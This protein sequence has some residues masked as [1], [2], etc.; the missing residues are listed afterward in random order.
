MNGPTAPAVRQIEHLQ[1]GKGSKGSFQAHVESGRKLKP[2]S[3]CIMGNDGASL[4]TQRTSGYYAIMD[5]S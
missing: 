3:A 5:F 1:Q 2:L 4:G